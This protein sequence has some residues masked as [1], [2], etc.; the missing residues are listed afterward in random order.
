MD[1]KVRRGQLR[2]QNQECK[3]EICWKWALVK[4]R[5]CPDH[6]QQTP[7]EGIV[8]KPSEPVAVPTQEAVDGYREKATRI[9]SVEQVELGNIM[10]LSIMGHVLKGVRQ[11]NFLGGLSL[12]KADGWNLKNHSHLTVAR[13]LNE[14]THSSML[15][16]IIREVGERGICTER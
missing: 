14:K 9:A 16:V 12:S 10:G 3:L 6:C 11:S 4:A 8:V 13:H 5:N 15:V 1:S 2:I 7:D